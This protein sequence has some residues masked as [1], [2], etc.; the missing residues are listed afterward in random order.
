MPKL[1]K[2]EIINKTRQFFSNKRNLYLVLGITTLVMI[3]LVVFL[4]SNPEPPPV[5]DFVEL[6]QTD[7][8]TTVKIDMQDVLAGEHVVIETP[9][10]IEVFFSL[11]APVMLQKKQNSQE[12]PHWLYIVDLYRTENDFMRVRFA[13]EAV[14]FEAYFATNDP[15]L[16]VQSDGLFIVTTPTGETGNGIISALD[17]YYYQAVLAMAEKEL[18]EQEEQP[19]EITVK[20]IVPAISV[21]INNHPAA[22]PSSGLQEADIIYEF[23]VEGGSTRYLA[24]YRTLQ[25]ANFSIGPIRSLRPYF[26]VQ[27]L[28]H[29][30]II[31]HSGYSERTRRMVQGM[32]LFQIADT[33]NNFWRDSSRRAPHNLYTNINNLYRAA[34]D[35]PQVMEVTYAV[36]EEKPGL[37]GK[38]DIIEI[39]YSAHNRVRYEYD[40]EQEVYFRFINGEPHT[41]LETGEQYTAARVIVRETLHK[42]VPGPEGL[43]DIELLGSGTG[44]LYEKGY[45]YQVTWDRET[46]QTVYRYVH[47]VDVK[48]I[49]QTTWIQVV[50]R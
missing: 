10:D 7:E 22:R 36:E 18:E 6:T 46:N 19:A 2:E 30:G 41:E 9:E 15:D 31:A 23:L 5:Y 45:E 35:R 14:A 43:V 28:E 1:T 40:E 3:T 50:R 44:T 38:A 29:G 21:V 13:D 33:G 20:E 12:T 39:N 47:G 32:G 8:N 27:S 49:P 26:A 24:V 17:S 16:N 11:M 48:P 4:V 37:F 25:E 42:N 34:G